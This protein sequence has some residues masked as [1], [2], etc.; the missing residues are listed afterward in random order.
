MF[1]SR[2]TGDRYVIRDDPAS[3][4][5]DLTDFPTQDTWY[6]LDLSNII[7]VRTKAVSLAVTAISSEAA[8]TLYFRKKGFTN[9]IEGNTLQCKVANKKETGILIIPCDDTRTIQ[10]FISNV[11]FTSIDI[12]ITGW[13]V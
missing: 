1:F 5:F 3:A 2:P 6:D 9:V 11:T 4:D 7:P 10:G 8:G 13:F 12:V